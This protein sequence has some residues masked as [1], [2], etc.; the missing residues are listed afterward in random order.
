LP[1]KQVRKA[2]AAAV[3]C[4]VEL[5]KTLKTEALAERIHALIADLI[6][7]EIPFELHILLGH[8]VVFLYNFGK[9]KSKWTVHD[10][11]NEINSNIRNRERHVGT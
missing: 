3:L 4:T 5:D 9:G 6:V 8:D 1:I 7:I 10:L 11:M 2:R